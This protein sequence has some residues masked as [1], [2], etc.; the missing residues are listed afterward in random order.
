MKKHCYLHPY[1][2]IEMSDD[3][4]LV[5]CGKC[6]LGGRAVYAIP[7]AGAGGKGGKCKGFRCGGCGNVDVEEI[8]M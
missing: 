4:H 7:V 5:S 3:K 6:K 8:E 2:R 1:V